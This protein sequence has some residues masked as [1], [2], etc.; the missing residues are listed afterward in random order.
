MQVM[1]VVE[2]MDE[3]LERSGERSQE[4][5]QPKEEPHLEWGQRYGGFRGIKRGPEKYKKLLDYSLVEQ[6]NVELLSLIY[7]F[8]KY[9]LNIP[10]HVATFPSNYFVTGVGCPDGCIVENTND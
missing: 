8:K 4:E 3:M 10:G 7:S 6:T 2:V 1:L 9:L 5:Q